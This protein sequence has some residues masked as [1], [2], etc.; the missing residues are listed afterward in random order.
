MF[1]V[2]V[3]ISKSIY[4]LTKIL[5]RKESGELLHCFCNKNKERC[6]FCNANNN[7]IYCKKL[8]Y[9][10]QCLD[11]GYYFSPRKHAPWQPSH[12]KIFLYH[13]ID[14]EFENIQKPDFNFC[15]EIKYIRKS[16][17]IDWHDN[18]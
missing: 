10:R 1:I 15:I 18:F 16:W 4:T 14:K 17:T 8:R 6:G 5:N 11:N 9:I 13:Q 2:T 3:N 7:C 12:W